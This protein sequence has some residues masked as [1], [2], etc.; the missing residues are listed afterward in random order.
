MPLTRSWIPQVV[1]S[2]RMMSAGTWMATSRRLTL[3][4]RPGIGRREVAGRAWVMVPILT[5]VPATL[6]PPVTSDFRLP[7]SP[8]PPPPP[9]LPPP[10]SPPPVFS[11]GGGDGG[12]GT[13][14]GGE[15]GYGGGRGDPQ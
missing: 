14:D 15:G 12:G 9:L 7:T 8:R 3:R 5:E 1:E 4:R 10:P 2:A 6:P 13:L 11:G